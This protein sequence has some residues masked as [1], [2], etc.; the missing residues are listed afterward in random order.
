MKLYDIKNGS[1][2]YEECSDG[3]LFFIFEHPDGMYSYCTTEKGGTVH[4]GMTQEL[5]IYKDGYKCV[6][7]ENKP[8]AS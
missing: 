7:N 5:K 6:A 2:I 1:K 4:L 8:H 3:S